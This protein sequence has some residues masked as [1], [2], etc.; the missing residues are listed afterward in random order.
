MLIGPPPRYFFD[1]VSL[2]DLHVVSGLVGLALSALMGVITLIAKK[3][4]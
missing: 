2:T 3:Y 4:G 1:G